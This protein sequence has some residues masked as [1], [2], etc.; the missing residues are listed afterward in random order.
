GVIDE[1]RQLYPNVEFVYGRALGVHDLIVDSL[2]DRVL[3][4]AQP[5]EDAAALIIG[6]GSSD[7]DVEVAL[8]EIARRLHERHPFQTVDVCF[9]YGAKP[10]F[11]EGLQIQKQ[12]GHKQVFVIPYLLFTGIL[13]NEITEE[14]RQYS[15]EKQQF[16]LCD[17][18]GF[19]PNILTVLK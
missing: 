10:G 12:K 3:E 5:E 15:T 11:K 8:K 1:A 18:L 16:I 4:K 7:P 6:R 2:L 17:S 14:I 9:M 13:M 19:H